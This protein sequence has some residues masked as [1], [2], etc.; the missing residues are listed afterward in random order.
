MNIGAR[1]RGMMAVAIVAILA[2]LGGCTTPNRSASQPCERC[3]TLLVEEDIE[4]MIRVKLEMNE[5]M[6]AVQ[7]FWFQD[8]RFA[9]EDEIVKVILWKDRAVP[10]L[11][12]HLDD[13]RETGIV[14]HYAEEGGADLAANPHRWRVAQLVERCLWHIFGGDPP[15]VVMP[16]DARAEYRLRKQQWQQWWAANG[17]LPREQWKDFI[18]RGR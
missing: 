16:G 8:A 13:W 18:P 10:A 6:D 9:P 15:V 12:A 14:C 3:V 5:P 7:M 17:S 2:A 1:F 4:K 11:L